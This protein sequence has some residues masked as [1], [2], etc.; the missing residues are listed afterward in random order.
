MPFPSGGWGP[1]D[2]HSLYA[3]RRDAKRAFEGAS[4]SARNKLVVELTVKISAWAKEHPE[5]F[6]SAEQIDIN[7]Q[8]VHVD[9]E[10]AE[11]AKKVAELQVKRTN[12]VAKLK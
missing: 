11:L 7:N 2:I 12:L 6:Q 9:E 3:S 1:K 8:L 4:P 5:A 10:L